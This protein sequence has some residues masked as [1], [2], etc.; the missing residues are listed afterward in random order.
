MSLDSSNP[1]DRSDL[2]GHSDLRDRSDLRGRTVVVSGAA[3]GL[4]LAIS[5]ACVKRGVHVI[6]LDRDAALL[7]SAAAHLR[8]TGGSVSAVVCDISV[9]SEVCQV[10]EGLEEAPWGLVNNAALADGVGGRAFWE[11]STEQWEQVLRVNLFGTWLM[12]KYAAKAMIPAGAGR[13]I[14]MAS[15]AALYGS[16]RLAH[17][18]A[19]KG[20]VM[21]L[22]R[23]MAR[24]LGPHGICVNSIAPGLTVGPSAENIPAERHELYASGRAI[25]RA[26]VPEDV[27][28]AAVF[29]LSDQSAFITG[30][31][32]V[33]DGGFVMN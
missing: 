29:L 25:E 7:D 5:E 19:S 4:G 9:E 1:R 28:G 32:I 20:G 14:N 12:S 21:A 27:A 26:Q 11:I 31:T 16:P 23:G 17:Y 24:D 6:A 2:Q 22:T 30:Q 33:V 10:F 18:I 8:S 15:D 13:I 3:R